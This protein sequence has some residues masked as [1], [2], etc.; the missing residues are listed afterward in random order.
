MSPYRNYNTGDVLTSVLKYISFILFCFSSNLSFG[1]SNQQKPNLIIILADDLG[2]GDLGIQGSKQIP[3]PHI[4]QLAKE[5]VV[6]TA[7]YVSSPVCS[8][9]R[10]G[11]LT[12]K[13]QLS[14]GYNNNIGPDQ[15]GFDPEFKGLPRCV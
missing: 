5:G 9:S 13:N 10:A 6:F 11:L 1:Q 4:D 14:F 15:P 7:G 3:T 12:G 2:Y 8:P